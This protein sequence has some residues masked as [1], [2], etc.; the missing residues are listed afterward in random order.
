MKVQF[1]SDEVKEIVLAY[2]QQM[3]PNRQFNSVDSDSYRPIP[4]VTV[5][6]KEE[7]QNA[8]Q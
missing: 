5:Y 8:A 1:S 7:E 6:F 4:D 2:V 3:M